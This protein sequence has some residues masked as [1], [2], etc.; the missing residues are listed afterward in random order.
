MVRA[1][2]TMW[3]LVAAIVGVAVADPFNHPPPTSFHSANLP[4]GP[5]LPFAFDD[6][7]TVPIAD[8][9]A[10]PP[11]F[12]VQGWSTNVPVGYA[13]PY[14]ADFDT[15][16]SRDDG[17]H[18][19]YGGG[20]Y[21]G[22]GYGSFGGDYERYDGG[23]YGTNPISNLGS[24]IGDV[25]ADAVQY[26]ALTNSFDGGRGYAIGAPRVGASISA[27][28][29]FRGRHDGHGPARRTIRRPIH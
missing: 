17:Y 24:A 4:S 2:M 5:P 6:V 20:G 25:I 18:G 28:P 11:P 29:V 3:V 9:G 7:P 27:G 19:I 12:G 15:Y 13:S 14:G 10:V 1:A 21:Y 8:F 22:G 23:G 16:D 26:P